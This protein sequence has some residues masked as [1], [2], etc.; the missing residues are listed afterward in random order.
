[1]FDYF[2]FISLSFHQSLTYCI[3]IR[4]F[5]DRFFIEQLWYTDCGVFRMIKVLW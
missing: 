4:E 3:F 1:M 5:L 2:L